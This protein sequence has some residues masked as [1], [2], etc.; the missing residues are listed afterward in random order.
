MATS[1][2]DK[3]M[4]CMYKKYIGIE[5]PGCGFQRSIAALLKG[6]LVESFYLFPALIPVIIMVLFLIIH[7][8]MKF[9]NGGNILMWMFIANAVIIIGSFIYNQITFFNSPGCH[10]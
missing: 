1:L 2:E 5:C 6:D 4:P 3:M 9:S 7:L 8:K 10:I